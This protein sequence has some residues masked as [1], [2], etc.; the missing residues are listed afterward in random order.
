MSS[1][2]AG[3]FINT[4]DK[5]NMPVRL[6]SQ[7]DE[8]TVAS[9]CLTTNSTIIEKCARIKMHCTNTHLKSEA[10]GLHSGFTTT[11]LNR[12]HSW[13]TETAKHDESELSATKHSHEN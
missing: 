1:K 12:S 2:H 11:C 5:K 13:S 10:S 4:I 7:L 6:M 8:R 9:P 3:M